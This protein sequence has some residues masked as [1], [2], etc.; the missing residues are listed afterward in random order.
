MLAVIMGCFLICQPTAAYW[1][2]T[3]SGSHCGNSVTLWL[4]T[5][6][7]NIIT[8]VVVLLLPMPYIVGLDLALYKKLVLVVTFGAGIL[9]VFTAY[10]HHVHTSTFLSTKLTA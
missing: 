7:L 1:D 6:I 2:P 10:G 4:T 9:Y 8:D 3:I 5:G